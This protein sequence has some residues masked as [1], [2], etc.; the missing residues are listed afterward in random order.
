MFGFPS[1]NRQSVPALITSINRQCCCISSTVRNQSL[2]SSKRK[3]KAQTAQ[4]KK[5]TTT[6]LHSTR[7]LKG[8]SLP[9]ES[10]REWPGNWIIYSKGKT[11]RGIPPP[12]VRPI[13]GQL[14]SPRRPRTGEGMLRQQHS[15]PGREAQPPPLSPAHPTGGRAERGRWGQ[16]L[17]PATKAPSVRRRNS[18]NKGPRDGG[19]GPGG[20]PD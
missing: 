19:R 14:H 13:L 20:G 7:I 2:K 12:R 9:A 4:D 8:K 15:Q 1:L 16:L 17:R 10:I 18:H 11:R 5:Y 3:R 6:V